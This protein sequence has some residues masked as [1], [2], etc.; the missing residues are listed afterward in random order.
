MAITV[1]KYNAARKLCDGKFSGPYTLNQPFYYKLEWE[2]VGFARRITGFSIPR[3]SEF[4][5][6]YF[7]G[8]QFYAST[9]PVLSEK[10][11]DAY[12]FSIANPDADALNPKFD[13]DRPEFDPLE[14]QGCMDVELAK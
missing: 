7:K 12:E 11:M 9:N 2:G 10:Y 14:W 8:A 4:T 3:A 5:D 1:K 13:P 6:A